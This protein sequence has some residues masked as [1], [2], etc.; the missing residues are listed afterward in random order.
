MQ[1]FIMVVAAALVCL[2]A[3][4]VWGMM[5]LQTAT[6]GPVIDVASRPGEA[7]VIID[8]QQDFT[9]EE[10]YPKEAVE[11]ALLRINAMV[12]NAH[13][14]GMP[15]INVRHVFKG[16]YVNFLVRLMSGGRGG[17]TSSGLGTDPRLQLEQAVEFVKHRGDAFSNPA[18]G[19]WLDEH[20]IGKLVIVGLDGNACV[21]ST[22]D[23]A[24][25][26]GYQVEI[27]GPAV[28]AQSA[29]SWDKQKARLGFRGVEFTR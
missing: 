18:F 28:L 25:N 15:V 14:Q 23:G 3:Y 6:K 26:R 11:A 10:T 8:V 4:T 20:T 27:V 2:I 21:K 1:E 19:R 29:P 24:L 17:E 9:S 7:L 12:R 16:P 13:G 22:A 5:R